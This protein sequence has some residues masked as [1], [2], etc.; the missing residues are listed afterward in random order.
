MAGLLVWSGWSQCWPLSWALLS[1]P[2]AD[3]ILSLRPN[4]AR[5]VGGLAA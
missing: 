2:L 5:A 4:L 3:A 1:L